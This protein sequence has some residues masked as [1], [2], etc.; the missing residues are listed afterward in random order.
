[1][2]T[3]H[4][5]SERLLERVRPFKGDSVGIG[6]E[7]IAKMP[8]SSEAVADIFECLRSENVSDLSWGLWFAQGVLDS[9]PPQELLRFLVRQLPKWIAHHQEALREHALPLL[10]RLRENFPGYRSMML[11]CLKDPDPDVRT[12]AL[13]AY[14]TF[15]TEKDIPLLLEFEQ[16]DYMSETSMNSP[17]I[18]AIRNQALAIIERLCGQKFPKHENVKAIEDGHTV[19]W[20]DWRPFLD[21]W[22][23]QRRKW[24]FWR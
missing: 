6:I 12:N 24:R 7:H 16:D 21:W 23:K 18:Y 3:A 2:S 14:E 4:T 11:R 17:L 9:N 15:L 8:L 20:W 19:Y 22:E 13:A 5:A 1:M 10:I